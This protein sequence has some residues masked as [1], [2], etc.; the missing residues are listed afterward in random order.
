MAKTKRYYYRWK[1]KTPKQV[2]EAMSELA[3][4]RASKMTPAQRTA[5]GKKM[6][7]AR[8]TKQRKTLQEK[9]YAAGN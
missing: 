8:H 9:L 5:H 6:I 1:N 2:S 4:K 3:S 7:A